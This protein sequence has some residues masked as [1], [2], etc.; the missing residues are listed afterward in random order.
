[1]AMAGWYTHSQLLV[2]VRPDYPTM[3]FNT[4]FCML[5][6]VMGFY[7]MQKHARWFAFA[8]FLIVYALTLLTLIEYIT[9]RSFGIDILFI[10]PFMSAYSNTPGRI[11]FNTDVGLCMLSC[12]LM[13]CLRNHVSQ[14][15]AVTIA[16]LAC[17]VFAIGAVPLLGY[18][19][20]IQEAYRAGTF[21]RMSLG[22]SICLILFSALLMLYTALRSPLLYRWLPLP[23]FIGLLMISFA[24][25]FAVRMHERQQ[26]AQEV[27]SQAN[28]LASQYSSKLQ[29]LYDA[30]NRIGLRWETA[31][32]TPQNLW[33]ADA[34]SYVRDLPFL[35]GVSWVDE[36]NRLR[37]LAPLRGRE[38]L[39]G[40]VLS[41]DPVRGAAL[42]K[43]KETQQAQ[44]TPPLMF[45]DGSGLGF[46][47]IRPLKT[48]GEHGGMI[49]SGIHLNDFFKALSTPASG[50]G[51]YY[52]LRH[53][54]KI[55]FSTHPDTAKPDDT[56][57]RSN[58]TITNVNDS[59]LLTLYPTPDY[60]LSHFT[61][62][63]MMVFVG[64]GLMSTLVALSAMLLLRE[65][66]QAGL[67]RESEQS[68]R[69][70]ME[71]SPIGMALV[72]PEGKW[73][74]VNEALCDIV[75]YRPEELLRTDFQNITHPEDLASDLEHVHKVIAGEIK[76]YS[77]EKRY[78]HKDGRLIPILLSVSLIRNADGSPKY[79]ISMIQDISERE[80]FVEQLQHMNTELEQFAYVASHDLQEPLRMVTSFVGLLGSNYGDKLDAE[81]KEFVEIAV[82]AS[83]RM[84]ALISD[85][86]EYARLGKDSRLSVRIDCNAEM[87]HVL[88]NLDAAIKGANAAVYVCELP[89]IIGNPVEFLRLMQNLIGNAIKFRRPDMAPRI[90]V[91]AER[92]G[93]HWLFT[94]ED[95][96][97]GMKSDYYERIFQP[98]KRLHNQQEYQGSGIGLAVCR[99][100]VENFGGKISVES[101]VGVGS[102]MRFTVPVIA[103]EN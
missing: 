83:K 37:W 26:I 54:D 77:M 2:Q 46:V 73:L 23:L 88:L 87:K 8:S 51:F 97:I 21:T 30:L 79:F 11:N 61:Y 41:E 89:D 16:I 19:S 27:Q 48:T 92:E 90:R 72:S 5:L 20:G 100:I 7:A 28:L 4:G 76:S 91:N 52:T 6:C 58:A 22:A 78:F 50:S 10:R 57:W 39:I 82:E 103:E 56:A 9:N 44:V 36:Q 25:A 12:G 43:A 40:K 3:Q 67:L 49:T 65:R 42:A 60:I 17:L 74:R 62:V 69:L 18:A 24:A 68:F 34:E 13:A 1:M 85:L 95:N 33:V 38:K 96:G 15:V 101:Q 31:G 45:L 29:D 53:G 63:P 80:Q 64:G 102:T 84:Q 70:A 93:E 35:S 75:G 32:G 47:Y 55:I 99:K 14:R 81:G 66:R 71:Y 86:L 94:V 59:Y 98:F